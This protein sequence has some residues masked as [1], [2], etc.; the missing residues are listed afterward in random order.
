MLVFVLKVED[1]EKILKKGDDVVDKPKA[2]CLNDWM[3][4]ASVPSES[5]NRI[6]KAGDILSDR[7]K[8]ASASE[9]EW[10]WDLTGRWRACHAYPINT[11][12]ATLRTKTK[13]LS[14]APIVAQRL[15]RMPT[16]IDKLR[17]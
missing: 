14:G 9:F 11:F 12:Q 4:F 6:N 5:G 3:P 17:R 1:V 16:I 10:A 15:K 8:R 7:K 2:E 13:D